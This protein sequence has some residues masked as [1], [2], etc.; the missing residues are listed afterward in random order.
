M[1]KAQGKVEALCEL[2]TG[3]KAIAFCRQC[4]E[5][6]CDE[7]TKAHCRM[8]MFAGH[9]VSTLDELK[10]GRAKMCAKQAPP[11]TCKVHDEQKKIYCY[12][13]KH[14][15]CR[16]CVIDEHKGHKYEFLKKAASAIQQKLTERLISL[17]KV[18]VNMHDASKTI[19]STKS[20]VES[21]GA[22]AAAKIEHSFKE[23]HSILEQHKQELLQKTSSLVKGKLIALSV[24][25]KGIDMAADMIQ[26][27]VECVERNIENATEEELVSIHTQVL[28]RIDE[29][30]KKHETS[31]VDFEPVEEA[32]IM[33]EVRC[34]EDL[35]KLC[36][37]KAIAVSSPVDPARSTVEGDGIKAAEVNKLSKITLHTMSA[38]EKPHQQPV[39]IEAKMTSVSSGT[40]IPTKVQKNHKG[41]YEIE[42]TP[43]V[44]GR[45][46]L[47]I[48]VNG[49][50]VA[51]SPF[52]VFVA[53]PPTKLGKTMMVYPGIKGYDACV[54]SKDKIVFT[55]SDGVIVILDRD[56]KCLQSIDT[57]F[58]GV[59]TTFSIH[60]AVDENCDIYVTDAENKRV[61]VFDKYGSKIKF[62]KPAIED[63]HLGGIAVSGNRV[64]VADFC[65]QLLL[66]T[67]DF[68]LQKEIDLFGC[69]PIGVA[70]DQD[71]KIYVCDYHGNCVKVLSAQGEHLYSFGNKEIAS[72][73]LDHPHSICVASDFVYVS[74]WGNNHCVSVFTKEG[75]FIS[76]F[77]NRGHEKGQFLRPCGLAI[78]G[79]GFLYVCDCGNSRIQ[80]F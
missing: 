25:E 45:H 58:H 54:N 20:D 12:D 4:A 77:G 38:C 33:V 70:C 28:D 44:Q 56:R 35:R 34:A 30:T 11:P 29:E 50:P 71:G 67:K 22:S 5:F 79:D 57:S 53:I 2:C 63:A 21:Q 6:I 19:K 78:D 26:S 9:K 47:E 61:V 52:C 15:I 48:T 14:L 46:Q 69:T 3:C 17:K 40:I 74:E 66:F 32:D 80:V 65:G 24:Q 73:K 18:Q 31:N 60:V 72:K 55:K 39:M 13:C 59:K 27:L 43:N 62:I 1:E 41:I 7:C 75:K 68:E 64:I 16:D 49:L 76:S 10:E 23:L 37:D 42:Y 8:K 36:H 51:G